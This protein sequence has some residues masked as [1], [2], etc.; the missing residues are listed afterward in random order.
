MIKI[1]RVDI[2]TLQLLWCVVGTCT[3]KSA[4]AAADELILC[5]SVSTADL[6]KGPSLL[7]PQKAVILDNNVPSGNWTLHLAKPSPEYIGLLGWDTQYKYGSKRSDDIR[8]TMNRTRISLSTVP[9]TGN[10]WLRSLITAYSKELTGAVWVEGGTWDEECGCYFPRVRPSQQH[11]RR[12][13]FVKD[14][15]P[16][17]P[18]LHKDNTYDYYW[19]NTT[20]HIMTV[21]NPFDSR[22]SWNLF[23]SSKRPPT[24]VED[25]MWAWTG[26]YTYHHAHTSTLPM[27]TMRYEDMVLDLKGSLSQM[28][29]SLPPDTLDFDA[30]LIETLYADV[31][32][33][34]GSCGLGLYNTTHE[35][36]MFVKTS[37]DIMLKRYGYILEFH[38]DE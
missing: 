20:F 4:G 2:T 18:M 16:F 21:R 9:R 28:F 14:H 3:S 7:K 24:S 12:V 27:F 19:G 5:R 25:Y 26:H 8:K 33:R 22:K 37:F 29:A 1:K 6:P 35:E 34:A 23:I 10:H 38:A 17:Q 30:D 15:A 13:F 32:P 11:P 36:L 31:I